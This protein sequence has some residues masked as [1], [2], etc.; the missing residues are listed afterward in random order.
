MQLQS[1]PGRQ[2]SL[3][4]DDVVPRESSTKRVAAAALYHCLG[5][6]FLTFLVSTAINA[7]HSV[8]LSTKD[9]VSVKQEQP[10]EPITLRIK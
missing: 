4:F 7:Q 6:L 3:S 8:V 10:Y 5:E 1:L 2:T 9:L